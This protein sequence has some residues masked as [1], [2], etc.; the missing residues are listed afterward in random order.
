MQGWAGG[1]G[2]GQEEGEE[3]GGQG[4]SLPPQHHWGILGYAGCVEYIVA[5]FVIVFILKVAMTYCV[6]L[7]ICIIAGQAFGHAI[8]N[9][10]EGTSVI[11][12]S[13][14]M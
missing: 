12:A 5:I 8:F 4:G 7:F 13:K 9:T 2:L 3:Q 14:E 11:A 10:G 6:E 1:A